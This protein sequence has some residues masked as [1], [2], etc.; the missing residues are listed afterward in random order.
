MAELL[1]FRAGELLMR[2]P[3]RPDRTVLGRGEQ[4][5]FQLPDRAISRTQCEIVPKGDAWL[6][7]DLSGRGTA[8]SH[9]MAGPNGTQLRDGDEIRLGEYAVV[10]GAT[11]A[12]GSPEATVP[13][14]A[15]RGRTGPLD[16]RAPAHRARLRVSGRDGEQ[17]IPLRPEEG[18]ALH[19]GTEPEGT[20]QLQLVDPFA[21]AEH[22]VIAF[23]SGAWRLVDLQS[24]NGTFVGELRV[25][26]CWLPRRAQLRAG[27][28]TFWFEQDV[29]AAE[30]DEAQEPLP[31][32]VTRDPAMT[33]VIE[34]VRRIAT[35]NMPVSIHGESGTGKEVIARAVHL[36][37]ERRDG[38]FVAVN[39]GALP[40]ETIESELFG[41]EKGAFTG[42][43][44]ARPGLFEEADGGTLFLD[45]IGDL[46]LAMQV[47]I[48]RT[49]ERGEVRRL[50]S[51]K[52][53]IV[54]VRFVSATHRDL[55]AAVEEGTFREDLFWRLCVAPVELPPL[56]QRVG[57]IMPLA[58][59]FARAF[60]PPGATLTFSPS[61]RAR[62]EGHPWPGNARELRNTIQL[63]L[64]QRRGG[65]VTDEDI[66]LRAPPKRRK[67]LD[68]L[69]VAGRTLGEI[70]REAYRLAVERHEGD[71]KAAMKELDVAR[72]TYFRKLS[73]FG[74]GAGEE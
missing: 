59:H 41:H 27:E 73:E 29:P 24:K 32:L 17:S 25:A 63:A 14:R 9:R 53:T 50:G 28:T 74:L 60:L 52:T 13:R 6:V 54:D 64:V 20:T 68:S 42:A 22:F 10:F 23:R 35:S 11:D 43:D 3:L 36:L 71:N 34:V 62:L 8:V 4:A 15:R 44:K 2:A 37:S 67:S 57:D 5:S 56:R 55:G 1:F 39:C 70:E 48:L 58:E 26:E 40:K 19:V 47:K 49:L 66:V 45:E 46:P 33:P 51:N 65:V 30:D 31:G 7:V 21:S 18:F 61:A 38:P 69:K 12:A 16:A 72:S